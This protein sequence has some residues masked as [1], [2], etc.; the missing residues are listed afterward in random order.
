M[1]E[2][3]VSVKIH[4]DIFEIPPALYGG[5][6]TLSKLYSEK[7][8]TRI[9]RIYR[10]EGLNNPGVEKG[11]DAKFLD[12]GRIIL[13]LESNLSKPIIIYPRVSAFDSVLIYSA[14]YVTLLGNGNHIELKPG[15]HFLY[16]RPATSDDCDLDVY[17]RFSIIIL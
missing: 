17:D 2:N 11:A 5:K 6:I 12:L 3:V 4:G 10:V 1:T 15:W 9:L 7:L 16:A 14:D 13:K 8:N